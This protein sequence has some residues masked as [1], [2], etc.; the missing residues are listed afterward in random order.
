MCYTSRVGHVTKSPRVLL[1]ATLAATTVV[2]LV[3]AAN[4]FAGYRIYCN[5]FN[6]ALT[7]GGAYCNGEAQGVY[8]DNETYGSFRDIPTCEKAVAV[9][10]GRT[11]SFRCSGTTTSAGNDLDYYFSHGFDVRLTGKNN[12]S[13]RHNMQA[14]AYF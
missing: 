8:G 13:G 10:N 14:I 6:G 11:I 4:A 2:G 1:L 12:D 3:L 5:G 7:N 9:G